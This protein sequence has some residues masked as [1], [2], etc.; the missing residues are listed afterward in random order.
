M[1]LEQTYFRTVYSEN[2]TFFAR[3]AEC[4][5]MSVFGAAKPAVS[6]AKSIGSIAKPIVTPARSAD[7][8]TRSAVCIARPTEPATMSVDRLTR[9]VESSASGPSPGIDLHV[10]FR[11]FAYCPLPVAN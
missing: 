4:D 11:F 8:I 10:L 3:P 9:S 5:T 2:D 7:G 6:V 1:D